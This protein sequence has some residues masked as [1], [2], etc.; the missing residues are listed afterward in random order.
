[1]ITRPFHPEARMAAWCASDP[2]TLE[3]RA[4]PEFWALEAGGDAIVDAIRGARV[5][6][7][8]DR[9]DVAH[10]MGEP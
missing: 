10:G 8:F 3:E 9:E 7:L 5:E 1:V 4:G 2:E 6:P